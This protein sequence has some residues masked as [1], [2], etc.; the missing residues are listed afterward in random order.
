MG[1]TQSIDLPYISPSNLT[2][3]SQMSW[4]SVKC[5]EMILPKR[6]V[7]KKGISLSGRSWKRGYVQTVGHEKRAGYF[8][9]AANNRLPGKN[10][11]LSSFTFFACPNWKLL[12]SLHRLNVPIILIFLHSPLWFS[13]TYHILIQSCSKTM[14]NCLPFP[15]SVPYKNYSLFC[16]FYLYHLSYL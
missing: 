11:L 4:K 16:V 13:D 1:K 5:E 8:I 15:T 7:T 10:I 2:K 6:Y 3:L 12:G 9:P 14:Y